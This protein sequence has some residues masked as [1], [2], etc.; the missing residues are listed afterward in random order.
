MTS[1]ML[2]QQG[3]QFEPHYMDTKQGRMHYVDEGT[4]KPLVFIHGNPTWS[5]LYR[6]LVAGLSGS[7]RC[8]APDLIGF[9]KS[10]KPPDW[11]YRP[12]DHAAVIDQFISRLD[13]DRLT[14]VLH[15]FGG[16]IGLCW[17]INN[18]ERVDK[19][20][21]F[22][23]WMWPLTDD[24]RARILSTVMSSP[25]GQ[26]SCLYANAF[27]R[28]VMPA[29]FGVRRR[30]T[31]EIHRAYLARHATPD[32]RKGT[33]VFPKCLCDSSAWYAH[34]WDQRDRLRSIP[35]LMVWGLKDPAF[36]PRYLKRWST[37]FDSCRIEEL[38]DIGHYVPEEKGNDLTPHVSR[39]LES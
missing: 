1:E 23:T 13:L 24:W 18:P 25:I 16:P 6:H 36:G 38:A 9:G 37:V 8:V 10:D 31:R 27:T 11:S 3:Y 32:E 35:A 20:I 33:W 30:L 5:F 29:T 34:L 2:E 7:H 4:G 17:A 39:F 21:L 22:N 14:L 12:E 19:L 26:L 28:F 15:D